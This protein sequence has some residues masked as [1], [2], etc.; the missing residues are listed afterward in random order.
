MVRLMTFGH[1]RLSVEQFKTLD[2]NECYHVL[3]A[4]DIHASAYAGYGIVTDGDRF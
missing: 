4:T 2:A 1:F 3:V